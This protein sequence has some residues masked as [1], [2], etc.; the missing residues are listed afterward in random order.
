MTK[1]LAGLPTAAHV[2]SMSAFLSTAWVSAIRKSLF[3]VGQFFGSAHRASVVSVFG[4]M[5][6]L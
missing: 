3:I 5:P 1:L 4:S 2:A 6:L